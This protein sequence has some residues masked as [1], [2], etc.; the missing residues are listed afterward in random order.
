MLGLGLGLGLGRDQRAAQDRG[1]IGV[2]SSRRRAMV[3]V[4]QRQS[5][6]PLGWTSG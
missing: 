2:C 5:F 6:D 3:A 1:R 4:L